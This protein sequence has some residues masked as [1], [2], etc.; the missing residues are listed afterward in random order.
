LEESVTS[1]QVGPWPEEAAKLLA[2]LQERVRG[3][4]PDVYAHLADAAGSLA[5]AARLLVAGLA[6]DAG[7]DRATDDRATDNRAT[8][9]RPDAANDDDA[10]QVR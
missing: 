2:A 4:P 7:N 9:E 10:E 8:D 3:V 1:P 5:A 6:A